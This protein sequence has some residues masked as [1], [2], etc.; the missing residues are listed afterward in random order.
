MCITT[1]QPD[2]KTN[3]NLR[4]VSGLLTVRSFVQSAD[5]SVLKVIRAFFSVYNYM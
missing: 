5:R 2:T 1:H 4:V 3:L